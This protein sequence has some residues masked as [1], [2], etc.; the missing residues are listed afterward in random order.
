MDGW[1]DGWMDGRTDERTDGWT[2]GR[3]D[4]PMNK[5]HNERADRNM[6]GM[7]RLRYDNYVYIMLCYEPTSTL[8]STNHYITL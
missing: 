2:D 5:Q 4:G 6:Y 1:M 8:C 3:T 7:L